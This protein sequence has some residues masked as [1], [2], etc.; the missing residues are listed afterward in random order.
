[1]L[2]VRNNQGFT[3]VELMVALMISSF[4]LAGI[5][6][7][8]NVSQNT[9]SIGLDLS[10][11]QQNARVALATLEKDLRSVGYNI[12]PHVQTPILVASEYRITFVRDAD[13]NGVVDMGETISFFLDPNTSAFTV[14]NTPNPK[15]MVLRK[16]VS[17][18]LNPN[19]DPIAGYGD[20]V[21]SGITQQVDNDGTTDIRIFD[22]F[23]EHGA[24]LLDL[25]AYD[26]HSAAFGHTISDSTALG[27]PLGGTN[28]VT[29]AT[30]AISVICES[31]AIDEFLDDYQRVTLSTLV[32]PRNLPLNLH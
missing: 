20:I 1:M 11:A 31:E 24:S 16:V 8:F 23:D 32:A 30:I 27:R 7:I 14:S 22:Y 5:F 2:T 26:P 19:A 21:A 6:R 15:D 25:G 18:S 13:D 12:P 17:D 10:D 29:V 3:L 28:A 4:V 9:Q